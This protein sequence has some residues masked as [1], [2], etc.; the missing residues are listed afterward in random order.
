[1]IAADRKVGDGKVII[2]RLRWCV[3]ERSMRVFSDVGGDLARVCK[4]PLL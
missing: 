3:G 1:M 4:L 2:A